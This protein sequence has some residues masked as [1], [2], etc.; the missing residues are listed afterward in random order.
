MTKAVAPLSFS[1]IVVSRHRSSWLARCIKAVRQLDHPAF[2]CVIV[3]DRDSL[4]QVD[5][6]GLKTVAFDDANIAAARNAG[7]SAAAGDVCAFVDDDAVPEPMWLHHHQAALDAT[8][9]EASLGYVRGRNGISFQSQVAFVDAE[10]ETHA[11]RFDGDAP[12]VPKPPLG[13]A[14]KLVG[15]NMA[16]RR[17]TLARMAGFD[18]ALRFFLDDTDLSLR[19]ASAGG[20][21]AAAPLAQVHHGFAASERR[22]GMR[23]PLDLFD[24]GRSSAIFFRRHKTR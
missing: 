17:A 19:L 5:S 7:I 16:I 14:A 11:K 23:A 24:I 18:P 15:T 2:E 13:Q 21:I 6:D 1:V 20:R 9:A 12:F 4:S 22:T 3:A 8:G 10:A